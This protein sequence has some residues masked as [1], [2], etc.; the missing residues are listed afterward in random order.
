MSRYRIWKFDHKLHHLSNMNGSDPHTDQKSTTISATKTKKWDNL[1]NDFSKI[2]LQTSNRAHDKDELSLLDIP[3]ELRTEI[4]DQLISRCF[5]VPGADGQP[6]HLPSN[7]KLLRVC[8][9]T[10][11]EFEPLLLRCRSVPTT[12]VGFDFSEL[13]HVL[14]SLTVED[15]EFLRDMQRLCI[16]LRVGSNCKGAADSVR[17]WVGTCADTMGHV[18]NYQIVFSSDEIT[19]GDEP[20]NA[21]GERRQQLQDVLHELC[22]LHSELRERS[23]RKELSRLLKPFTQELSRMHEEATRGNFGGELASL[24]H[25]W[26][27]EDDLRYN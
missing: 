26:T 1:I 23:H 17:Q 22:P 18:W 3:A 20:G 24:I 19:T 7:L 10:K 25:T 21:R 6:K 27:P 14:L 16:K 5:V 11:L 15:G 9:Q 12:I 2:R 8:K 13:R 4:Y